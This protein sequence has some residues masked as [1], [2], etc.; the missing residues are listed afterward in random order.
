MNNILTVV[1][2]IAFI[3]FIAYN[4]FEIIMTYKFYKKLEKEHQDFI[5]KLIEETVNELLEGKNEKN[6]NE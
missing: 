2:I 1:A 4:I 6:I 3:L 5:E